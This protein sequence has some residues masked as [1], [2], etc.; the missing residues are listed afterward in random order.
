MLLRWSKL[1]RRRRSSATDGVNI[2]EGATPTLLVYTS[3]LVTGIGISGGFL[4]LAVDSL[5][6]VG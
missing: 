3:L 2:R 5:A 6:S 4:I 1:W